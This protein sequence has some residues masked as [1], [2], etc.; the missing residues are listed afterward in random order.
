M[1][2]GGNSRRIPSRGPMTLGIG[3]SF[4]L[5]KLSKIQVRDFISQKGWAI[6]VTGVSNGSARVGEPAAGDL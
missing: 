6:P 4:K 3:C 5:S 2:G 1:E